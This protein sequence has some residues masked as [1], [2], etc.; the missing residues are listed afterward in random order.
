MKKKKV[1]KEKK[2]NV[3]INKIIIIYPRHRRMRQDITIY[4]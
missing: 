2:E 3:I 1:N 4:S